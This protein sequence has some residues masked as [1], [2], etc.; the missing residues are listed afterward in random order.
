MEKPWVL[1][2]SSSIPYPQPPNE[3]E[4]NYAGSFSCKTS[5]MSFIT[6]LNN[7]NGATKKNKKYTSTRKHANE[8]ILIKAY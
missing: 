1:K 3:Q 5:R 2:L 6:Q 4:I 7:V 8:W